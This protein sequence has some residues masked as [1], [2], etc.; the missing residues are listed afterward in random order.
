[1]LIGSCAKIGPV[2]PVVID[3][4]CNWVKPIYLTANDIKVMDWQ[5]KRDILSHNQTWQ[6]NCQ[7]PSQ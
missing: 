1:M 6:K 4:A 2:P 5:T 3:T 7:T